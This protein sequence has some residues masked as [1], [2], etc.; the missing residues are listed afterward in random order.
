[1]NKRQL[2]ELVAKTKTI[3][4]ISALDY[5]IN[6]FEL[7]KKTKNVV[8]READFKTNDLRGLVHIADSSKYNHVILVNQN[9][10]FVEKNYHGTHEFMHIVT[11]KNKPGST[12]QCFEKIRPNQDSYIEWLANEGAAE[13]LMP[14]KD[15]LSFVKS[16]SS[17]FNEDFLPI[18]TLVHDLC[19]R[20]LVSEIVAQNR[21]DNLSYEIWQYL[22]GIELEDIEVISRSEQQKRGIKIDSLVDIENR[23]GQECF[24]TKGLINIS[25]IKPFFCYSKDYR[26]AI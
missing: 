17:H 24:A 26:F 21:L 18:Y 2:Y 8:I 11:A 12:I 16:K 20:Y 1:M 4:N 15:V 7:C 10:V 3:L 9:K 22:K 23:I 5:P 19:E 25:D 6:I 13:L 14:Y